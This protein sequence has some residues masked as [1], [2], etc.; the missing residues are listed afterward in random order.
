V[1]ALAA[2]LALAVACAGGRKPPASAAATASPSPQVPA[3]AE[4]DSNFSPP[5]PTQVGAR[6]V[7]AKLVPVPAADAPTRGPAG[8]PV[9][10][11]IFSDFEC[12]YCA[13]AAPLVA[14]TEA[15]YPGHVR[16]VWHN[17]PLPMHPHAELA[18]ETGL[19]VQAQL[20]AAAFWHF[21][22]AIFAAQQEGLSDE[23]I[24]RLAKDAGLDMNR[25]RTALKGRVHVA[26]VEAD[27]KAADNAE[28]NG[29]PAFFVN[30]WL[31]IGALDFSDFSVVVDRALND[32]GFYQA[33]AA[34]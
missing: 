6:Q 29:T 34:H 24:V 14:Q 5:D 15:A 22:D 25:Y 21:H 7:S 32:R 10:I 31:A 17:L 28:I 2:T 3:A 16:F 33:P 30:D 9:T 11:Q 13:L 27:L 4:A 26:K 12:P 19:E 1:V 20:G 23:L 18:A 8:A